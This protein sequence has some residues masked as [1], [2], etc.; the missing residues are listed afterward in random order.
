[1]L[2]GVVAGDDLVAV[3]ELSEVGIA[4]TGEDSQQAG[5]SRSVEAE[6]EQPFAAPEICSRRVS[7][8]WSQKETDYLPIW[9]GCRASGEG[10]LRI[11]NEI[12]SFAAFSTD[13]S[14]FTTGTNLV[15]DGALTRGVQ[16]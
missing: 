7:L 9:S 4:L 16:L 10:S 8:R 11:P 14:S 6:H 13:M 12:T 5:I 15:I 2:L 3:L 1:M